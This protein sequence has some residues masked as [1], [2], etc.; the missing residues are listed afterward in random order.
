MTPFES[1]SEGKRLS[2][3]HFLA[4]H[5]K[6]LYQ[7][8]EPSPLSLVCIIEVDA[9]ALGL[10]PFLQRTVNFWVCP[11]F[12]SPSSDGLVVPGALALPLVATERAVM[13]CA[14]VIFALCM[15]PIILSRWCESFQKMTNK[16]SSPLHQISG[17]VPRFEP[18]VSPS[19][20]HRD[21]TSLRLIVTP[22]PE[23]PLGGSLRRSPLSYRSAGLFPVS[24]FFIHASSSA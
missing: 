5:P 17:L 15:S 4:V 22:R 12:C 1:V 2:C 7:P 9:F 11:P 14:E 13:H 6:R 16:S 3:S 19:D 24:S 10:Q 21:Q 23:P 18:S 20:C 8:R